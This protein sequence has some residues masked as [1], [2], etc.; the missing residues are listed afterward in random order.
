MR[1]T[2]I[3]DFKLCCVESG[4]VLRDRSADS[5]RL[6]GLTEVAIVGRANRR[7]LGRDR[8]GFCVCARMPRV[9]FEAQA[10]YAALQA[11]EVVAAKAL[12]E[13][14]PLDTAST[15]GSTEGRRRVHTCSA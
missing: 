1:G 5:S 14:T 7:S 9:R 12:A 4:K 3:R 10:S 11:L 8:L 13:R 15:E 6:T 2:H